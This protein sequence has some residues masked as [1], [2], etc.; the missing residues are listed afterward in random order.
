MGNH[1]IDFQTM[2]NAA[3]VVLTEGGMIER[4]KRESSLVLD[5]QILH[6]GLIY[7]PAGRDALARIYRDYI[8]IAQKHSLPMLSLAPT[9][10]ANPQRI[11]LS[12][13]SDQGDINRDGV[14]F[15]DNIRESYGDY[16][17]S[18]Y[19][20]GLMACR[21]D[22]YRPEEALSIDAAAEFH[23]EQA[24]RL[25]GSGVDFIKA[26][27]LPAVSEALGLAKAIAACGVP[28][29]LSF[30][31]R[32]DGTVLDGSPIHEA[33]DLIDAA[34]QP[35]PFFYMI[36]CV[37]PSVFD[38]ALSCEFN[39]TRQVS[40]RIL[41]LQANT[42]TLSPAELGDLSYLDTT[43]PDEFAAAMIALHE[44]FGLKILGGCCGSDAGHIEEIARRI[45]YNRSV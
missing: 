35:K 36:N 7:D 45:P 5:P 40:D 37:H 44:K 2:I 23:A 15:L 4:I 10:R 14:E 11:A 33:I 28:Y 31:V 3:P 39:Y 22:A 25:A 12:A 1:G 38:K 42:S 8:D 43:E 18:I 20:G 24:A 32:P 21:G 30:V 34:V 26:A 13:F 17:R 19:I 9:W 6:A 29:V 41:G 27:T 16:S